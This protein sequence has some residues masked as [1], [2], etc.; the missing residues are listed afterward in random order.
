MRSGLAECLGLDEGQVRVIAPDVGG[1]FGSK[2][3]VYNEEA[4]CL[5][6][7][8]KLGVPVKWVEERSEGYLAT[9]HGRDVIQDME[10]AATEEGRLLGVRAKVLCDM[11]AY[12]QLVAP[13]IQVL[14]ATLFSGVYQAEAG[15]FARWS[16]AAGDRLELRADRP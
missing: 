11:G 9:I 10:V 3:D 1:G 13:G 8:R 12:C 2:L 14:G 5:A 4:I 6:V 16:L 15:S 7:A